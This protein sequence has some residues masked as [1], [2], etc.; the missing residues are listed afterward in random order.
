MEEEEKK[1]EKKGEEEEEKD[2]YEEGE[3][4]KQVH[5]QVSAGAAWPGCTMYIL[6]LP[7]FLCRIFEDSPHPGG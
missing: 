7:P 5:V 4:E 1:K 2:E 6:F 3:E